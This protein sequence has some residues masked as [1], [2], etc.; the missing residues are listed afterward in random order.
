LELP[1]TAVLAKVQLASEIIAPDEPKACKSASSFEFDFGDTPLT[2]EQNAKARE[3][4]D[5]K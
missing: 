5:R 4:L 3:V 2:E 1:P